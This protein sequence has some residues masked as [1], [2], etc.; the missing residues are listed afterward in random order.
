MITTVIRLWIIFVK[1]RGGRRSKPL[2]NLAYMID[3]KQFHQNLK[4]ESI[5]NISDLERRSVAL[6]LMRRSVTAEYNQEKY[7][8]IYINI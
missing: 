5:E 4:G 6:E 8:K 7:L 3:A 1:K 2:I